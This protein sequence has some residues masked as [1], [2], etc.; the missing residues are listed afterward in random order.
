MAH[1][2]LWQEFWLNKL[3]GGRKKSSMKEWKDDFRK[4]APEELE[5]LKSRF[6]SGLRQAADIAASGPFAHK[7][8]DDIDA[9]DTL[10]RIAVHG[11]YHMGQLNLIKRS[12]S[13]K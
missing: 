4:P 3:N 5:D 9:I 11:A 1:A 7:C 8:T 10:L 13:K 2:V 6:V 12:V